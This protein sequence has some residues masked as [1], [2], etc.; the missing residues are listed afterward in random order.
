MAFFD[1][2]TE[3]IISEKQIIEIGDIVNK[4]IPA[5]TNDKQIIIFAVGGMPTEDIA[6]GRTLYENA[7]KQKIGTKLNLW[8]KPEWS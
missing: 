4:K 7:V 2:V 6:W 3:K 1:A 5:R 8:E